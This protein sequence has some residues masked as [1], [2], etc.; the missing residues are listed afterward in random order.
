MEKY[1]TSV[2]FCETY[3]YKISDFTN[4]SCF[5][6]FCTNI[7]QAFIG[8]LKI[9]AILCPAHGYTMIMINA[10]FLQAKNNH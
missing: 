7:S 3:K 1:I 4:Y 2:I 9:G 8:V 5:S 6:I 10:S